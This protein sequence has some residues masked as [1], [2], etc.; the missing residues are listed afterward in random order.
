MW[1]PSALLVAW[2]GHLSGWGLWLGHEV[3]VCSFLLPSL[4]REFVPSFV[5]SSFRPII[6]SCNRTFAGGA[7][8][9]THRHTTFGAG[10]G[11]VNS[12]PVPHCVIVIERD[13]L[14]VGVG[15]RL[16]AL[17]LFFFGTFCCWCSLGGWGVLPMPSVL[18]VG[19]TPNDSVARHVKI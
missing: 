13:A 15:C 16:R 1:R 7:S 5:L 17:L 18:R 19:K 12:A 14:S 2:S 6:A 10:V 4:A 11:A 9:P 3:L 8:R